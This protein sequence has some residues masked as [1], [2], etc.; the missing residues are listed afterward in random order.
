MLAV[1]APAFDSVVI[2]R[3]H[4][5]RAADPEQL[6]TLIARTRGDAPQVACIEP[7]ADALAWA[8][9]NAHEITGGLV[10]VAGSIFL[11]GEARALVLGHGTTAEASDPLP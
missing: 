11:V 10:V 9:A 4:S 5:E 3:S 1:L 2:T 7:V 6:A 8:R